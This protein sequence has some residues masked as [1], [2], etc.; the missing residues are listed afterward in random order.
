MIKMNS[1]KDN[2]SN[3]GSKLIFNRF[4]IKKRIS[5]GKRIPAVYN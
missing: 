1:L 3:K 5:A 4:L 2:E